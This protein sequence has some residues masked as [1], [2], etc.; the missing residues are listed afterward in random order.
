M[1]IF[2]K[3]QKTGRE[4]L[5]LFGCLNCN[6]RSD[7]NC[8]QHFSSVSPGFPVKLFQYGGS[9]LETLSSNEQ[10]EMAAKFNIGLGRSTAVGR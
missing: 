2:S 9:S 7:C 4:M 10:C 5:E 6:G 1:R 3:H 8:W